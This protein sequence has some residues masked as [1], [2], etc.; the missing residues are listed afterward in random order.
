MPEMLH[1]HVQS[2]EQVQYMKIK[3]FGMPQSRLIT[4]TVVIVPPV[5]RLLL[6]APEHLVPYRL[7][8]LCLTVPMLLLPLR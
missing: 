2:Y 7:H 5:C 8:G 3:Q 6:V 4:Q 1:A